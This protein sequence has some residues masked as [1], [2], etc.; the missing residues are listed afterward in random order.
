MNKLL[1]LLTPLTGEEWIRQCLTLYADDLH[2]GCQ[3][4]TVGALDHHLRCMGHLLDCIERLKLQIS[5]QKSYLIFSHTGSNVR[6]ALKGRLCYLQ[7]QAHLLLSRCTGEA[8]ALPLKTMGR[9]LG[10]IVSYHAFEQQTWLHRKKTAWIAYARLKRWLRHRQIRQTHRVYLWHTCIH[11]IL[12][13]GIFGTGVTVQS[14]TDYQLT[15]FQM[16]RLLIGD[17]SYMTGNTH[18]RAIQN[19]SLPLPLQL[20]KHGAEKLW[21]RLQRR[22]LQLD[23]TDFLQQVDWQH[24]HDTMRLIDQVHGSMPEVPID[25]DALMRTPQANEPPSTA[26]PAAPVLSSNRAERNSFQVTAQPFWPVLKQIIQEQ[27]WHRLQEHPDI[28]QCELCQTRC[29][30]LQ[31]LHRHLKAEHDVTVFDW[32]FARVRQMAMIF[33]TSET[34]MFIP[35]QYNEQTLR[36]THRALAN[37]ARFQMLL[38]VVS[39]SQYMRE[40]DE[41]PL[42]KK[43]KQEPVGVDKAAMPPS[44]QNKALLTLIHHLA[45]VVLQHDRAIQMDRK[46]DSFVIFAQVSAEGALPLLT[47][48]AKEWKDMTEK[49]TTLRTY[50]LKHLILEIQQ[51]AIKLS[52]SSQGTQ[53]WDVA[54]S[55]GVI[56]QDGSWPFQQWCHT[57]KKL[58]KSHRAPLPMSRI[59]KD[60]QFMV[61]LLTDNDHVMRFH[62]LRPQ[63]QCG[64]VDATAQHA[65]GRSLETLSSAES[66]HPMGTHGPELEAAQPTSQQTSAAAGTADQHPGDGTQRT[67]QGEDENQGHIAHQ[68]RVTL[69]Q[70][71]AKLTL[72]NTGHMC[73]ANNAFTCFLWSALSRR[74]FTITDWGHQHALFRELLLTPRPQP[75]NLDAQPWFQG[76][77]MN[78]DDNRGQADSAEFTSMLLQWVAPS[79]LSCHWQRRLMENDCV[80][81]HDHSD[82]FQPLT[83]QLDPSHNTDGIARLTDMLRRW[84]NDLGMCAGLMHAPEVVCVHVDRFIYEGHGRLR[85]TDLPVFFGWTVDVPIFVADGLE[86]TWEPYQMTAAFAHQGDAATGHYQALLRTQPSVR[87]HNADTFWLHCDDDRPPRPCS[88]LPNQFQEGVTCIW[89]CRQDAIDL[90]AWEED[91]LSTPPGYAQN[92][93]QLLKLLQQS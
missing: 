47:L 16:I 88:M 11:T 79:F 52:Q 54:V 67:R 2:V 31:S 50:L 7:H 40:K 55:K 3:F 12:T 64:A 36:L 83:L 57:E 70:E 63:S 1:W 4:L 89:L 93:D 68:L 51:R 82:R 33:Y 44:Q 66:V 24:H 72:G 29:D 39:A 65:R 92:P 69:R 60:L 13:Y 28:G 15:I 84:H 45:K 71:V 22:A 87:H 6:H 9:Y 30:D 58:T 46:Q 19:Q 48:K 61:D 38:N 8:T 75:L 27:S 91:L 21:L 80:R 81:V 17:H 5:L 59:L 43:L 41:E 34:E 23:S 18:Q 78:W 90:H 76:I 20:L 14:L 32:N 25:G 85:K 35:Q 73:Y 42:N 77:T 26:A 62:S 74:N 37:H 53:L 10:V 86:C 56:L 49:T